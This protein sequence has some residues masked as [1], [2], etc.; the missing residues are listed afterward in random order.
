[1]STDNRFAPL[2][3]ELRRRRLLAEREAQTGVTWRDDCPVEVGR[4]VA[5]L[6]PHMTN[7][8]W[9]V[10]SAAD[11]HRSVSNDGS[12][13]EVVAVDVL[14]GEG[15]PAERLDVLAAVMYSFVG[16]SV[17]D[18]QTTE[19]GWHNGE[20]PRY[21]MH[22]VEMVNDFLLAARVEWHFDEGHFTPRGNSVLYAEVVKP[23]SVLLDEDPKFAQASAGFQAAITRLSENKPDVAITDAA[24]SVQ[25]FFRALGVQGNSI[26]KQL[27]NAQKVGVI[28]TYD[29]HLLKPF[30]DWTNSDRSER[31]NAH[32]HRE[33]DASK[34]D[35]WLAV[36]VAAA[37]MVR[38]S[39][40]EPRDILRAREKRQAD[41]LAAEKAE[42]VARQAQAQAA[43]VK[44]DVWRTPTYNDEVPF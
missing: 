7:K 16:L 23:A 6:L 18:E 30:V 29:R 19:D 5:A 36:H 31:G 17:T 39:N 9:V 12:P 41:A 8:A 37:L 4:K 13:A 32:H 44:S 38:L 34:S 40:E 24:S 15:T 3:S 2:P 1:M 35:A 27:D 25:E 43:Q 10:Y 28:T 11:E 26:S 42:E 14:K 21:D 20:P 22:F 33:G